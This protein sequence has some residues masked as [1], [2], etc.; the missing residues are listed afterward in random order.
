MMRGA[1]SELPS[2]A[3]RFRVDRQIGEGA[4]GTVLRATDLATGRTAALKVGH[5][6]RE[7]QTLA[8]EAELLALVDSPGVAAVLDAGL[9]PASERHLGPGR[10]YLALEWVGG[11]ALD[12]R[13][14]RGGERERVALSL[15][16]D[17]G[18]ALES[19][20]AAGVAHGDVK[21]ANV[22]MAE[23]P[24]GRTRAVLVDL[25]LA[26]DAS[27]AVP[28]GGTRRYLAPECFDAEGPASDARARDLWAL[29]V[30][31]AE[32]A[33]VDVARASDVAPALHAVKLPEALEAIVRPLLAR[34]PGARPSADWVARR[35]RDALAEPENAAER[36]AERRRAVRRSYL[37][38]RRPLLLSA[39]RGRRLDVAST[40]ATGE[41]L[42][43][44]VALLERVAV[45]RGATSSAERETVTDLDVLGRARWLTALV[46]GAAARWP[47]PHEGT[48]G[49][50]ADRLLDA[51]DRADPR[52]FTL[53]AVLDGASAVAS[54][55]SSDPMAIA[56]AL[57]ASTPS[58][59]VLDAAE[60]LLGQ[61]PDQAAIAVALGR[62]LRL[63][64]QL[65][66]A[67]AVLASSQA[68]EAHVEA[69]ECARRAGD[70]EAARAW[71][72]RVRD[73][74]LPFAAAVR[75]AAIRARLLL[76]AGDAAAAISLVDSLPASA[77][78]L[79][80]RVLA[81]LARGDLAGARLDAERAA[82]LAG[83]DEE[84][85]RVEAALGNVA[86]AAGES[87]RALDAFRR[88]A[89]HAAQAGAVLEE[90]TYLTGVA[91]AGFDAGELGDALDAATR[92]TLLFEHLGRFGDAGR[93]LLTR[94]AVYA[95]AGAGPLAR[96]AA[97][98][99]IARARL[100]G[101]VRCR[102]FA[103]LIHA[104]VSP[105][106]AP[107][108]L[109]HAR[110][111]AALL[112]PGTPSD[113]LRAAAR[114]HIRGDDVPVAELDRLAEDPLLEAPA[115]L[116]WWGARAAVLAKE[117]APERPDRVLGA[118]LAL[119]PLQ[120]P[121]SGRGEAMA[122]GSALAA[123]V[124]DGDAARH[125]AVATADAARK[126]LA[127]APPALRAGIAA[128]P[129]AAQ[130]RSP[131]ETSVLPEQIADIEA[132]VH[133]LGTRDRLRPLLDQALD[134]LVLWTGV[135]RGL[136]LLRAPEGR[137]VPRAAR[138]IARR[139]LHGAQLD[140]SRSLAERALRTLDTVVA[141]DATGEL[142]EVHASVHALKLR[143]VL[144]VPLVA[145]GE[146]LGV[147]Y[148]DDRVRRGAFGPG[149]LG[150]VRLVA[151]LAA[152]AIADA[153]DQLALRRAARRARRAEAR[154]A[155][156]LAKR[157][158]ELDVAER[159]LARTKDD[160]STRYAYDD[161]VGDSS[162][163][164]A[165]LALVD[166]V[167]PSEI[168]VL[169]AG[170]SGSGKELVARA[171]HRN[172]PRGEGPFVTE[173]CGAIPEGLLETTLFGHVRGAFTGA[174]RP[175][176]G[177]FEVASGG[178]LFLDEVG[179]M[180]LG[181][182]TKLLRVLEDGEVH[183]V[184]S[185]R[186]RKVDVRI[187]TAS[188]RDLSKMVDAGTFR[189]DLF[190]RLN[191]IRIDVPPLRAR[192]GDVETLAR[193]FVARHA[194]GRA[195]RLSRG[196][197]TALAAYSWPGNIRQLENELRRALVLA[198]DVIAPE[199]L[200]D[201]V[202]EGARAEADRADGLNVRRRVDALEATLVRAAL[203]RTSGN[204][205][206]AAELLGLSR[207]GLQKMIR[208]LGIALPSS[209]ALRDDTGEVTGV[210]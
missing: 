46:G 160:R 91:A 7:R 126:L 26:A 3:F 194:K 20:H 132:L 123:R 150:W 55:V 89:G 47:A 15:A 103:H 192:T 17:L 56:L 144:A 30:V 138:N 92:A 11:S 168:P 16:R 172:G 116:E 154:L 120:V 209:P 84:R 195:V 117:R 32:A 173:N 148:L 142:S 130:V 185:E 190:Y 151:S 105:L 40:G 37:S 188:H 133:T 171:I 50:L 109:E 58:S 88:A 155:Q 106:G 175:H 60:R 81:S 13:E 101:D 207:F 73:G 161:V 77:P 140:L 34:A 22:V 200:S 23:A 70:P 69:A 14:L 8:D 147:V 93:A 134:A 179:E 127:S 104:D 102:A 68:P 115:R 83:T 24:A 118:L 99:A 19:L 158:A 201:D 174:N 31:L 111:A 166:R 205:T 176:A 1:P 152:V 146:A 186:A 35:A 28:R 33:S 29:G 167:T 71:L 124:G 210:R 141:V 112:E 128:L 74:D 198:D 177:L 162:E 163:V 95:A 135:E 52:G 197:L 187:I 41:W 36:I 42:R 57:G 66:R 64:G 114:R 203:E 206:R 4:T 196:A 48:D 90:A 184:G 199:H 51:A 157:E 85:A 39:A 38:V 182:Q 131:R 98:D 136:L 21:P 67:L 181:M 100:A 78:T 193:H 86:H 53:G 137:L 45:L 25:G 76:D 159:E 75:S 80:V 145:R 108:G 178:T 208:R 6:A 119:S 96:E 165:L 183:P 65:G 54:T 202:R 43:D 10:P 191:V 153:R 59:A 72:A 180:S 156:S 5:G 94:A 143:S 49:A 170:E 63:R 139:D 164:R 129:W 125:F 204:Q 110:R 97:D 61:S 189:S 12:V 27:E 107:D 18:E 87:S 149:E 113:R 169:I 44:A 62:A 79:E 122:A 9:I 82:A 121:V 2:G